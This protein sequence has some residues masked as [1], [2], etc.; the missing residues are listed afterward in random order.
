MN[1][2]EAVNLYAA[3]RTVCIASICASKVPESKHYI[4][5]D[6]PPGRPYVRPMA[7]LR[8][9]KEVV[10]SK[11]GTSWLSVKKGFDLYDMQPCGS[12]VYAVFDAGSDSMSDVLRFANLPRSLFEPEFVGLVL[13][14]PKDLEFAYSLTRKAS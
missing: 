11:C 7:T 4:I 1:E 2:Q 5:V 3:L 13:L 14:P 10:R 6:L 9:L 8:Q 12:L